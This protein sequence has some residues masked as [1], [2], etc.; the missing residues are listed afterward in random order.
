M[1]R[2]LI[3]ATT[4]AALTAVLMV[5]VQA[6]G[7]GGRQGGA[8]GGDAQQGLTTNGGVRYINPGSPTIPDADINSKP[9]PRLP[10]GKIDIDRKSTRLN[11]S[12]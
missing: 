7:R 11:S 12:H 1:K 3:T 8:A 5:G 10:D 2:L 4:L 6:Q 9:I